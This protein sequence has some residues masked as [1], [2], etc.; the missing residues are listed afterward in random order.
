MCKTTWDVCSDGIYYS[1]TYAWYQI[2]VG[3]Y[4]GSGTSNSLN[5]ET[6][7]NSLNTYIKNIVEA[8]LNQT[9]FTTT[10]GEKVT[11]TPSP[12]GI[13]LMNKV[14]S[15]TGLAV[16][17]AILEMNKKFYLNRDTS[18][19]EWPNGSPF[20][21]MNQGSGDDTPSSGGPDQTPDEW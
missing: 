3:G 9:E 5:Y 16:V 14:T 15:T 2:A 7:A 18:K 21:D 4:T 17:E 20:Q 12:L 1:D 8:K 13:V 6:V 10:T 11:M 19:P